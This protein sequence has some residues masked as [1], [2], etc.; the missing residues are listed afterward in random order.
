MNELQE[1]YLKSKNEQNQ[2]LEEFERLLAEKTEEDE[3]VRE[4][5]SKCRENI[6]QLN[7]VNDSVSDDCMIDYLQLID[8]FS[9]CFS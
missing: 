8:Y 1:K 7:R 5:L 9:L 3:T 2:K 4:E 6:D